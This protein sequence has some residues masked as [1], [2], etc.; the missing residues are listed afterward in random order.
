MVLP[1]PSGVALPL[2]ALGL[3][4]LGLA[5]GH[6]RWGGLVPLVLGL[7]TPWLAERPDLLISPGGKLVAFR[8]PDGN[9]WLSSNRAERLVR[10]TW[11]RRNGQTRF[12]DV[13]DLTGNETWLRCSERFCDYGVDATVRVMRGDTIA[14][15]DDCGGVALLITPKVAFSAPCPSVAAI[16]QSDLQTGG[17]QAV[18][19]DGAIIRIETAVALTGDRPWAPRKSAVPSH[20]ATDIGSDGDQ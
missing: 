11:L 17:A 18:Y 1:A 7:S 20:I 2:L 3:L 15:A 10:E 5:R 9:L 13:G 16:E 12:D 4:W 6:W 19:L 8:A 14:T